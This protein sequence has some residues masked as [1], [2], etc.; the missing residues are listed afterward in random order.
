MMNAI[1]LSLSISG[2]DLKAFA[3][4]T[5]FQDGGDNIL[6]SLDAHKTDNILLIES[7][8]PLKKKQYMEYIESAQNEITGIF[9]KFKKHL[10]KKLAS[11]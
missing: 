3:L 5:Y 11:S 2:I 7:S 10:S 1:M 6:V 8:K 9:D 4:T